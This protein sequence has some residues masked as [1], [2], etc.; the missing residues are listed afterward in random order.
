MDGVNA[1]TF[2]HIVVGAGCAG[3]IVAA[4]IAENDN[5]N[6]LL[7]E[8]GPDYDPAKSLVPHGVQDARKVPM[9]GQSEVFDP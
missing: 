6:V 7:I 5:F 4:R 3:C 9:K 8:A 2:T 1:D